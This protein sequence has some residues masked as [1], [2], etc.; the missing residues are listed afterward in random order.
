MLRT[1]MRVDVRPRL[2][3]RDALHAIQNATE[4]DV[5]LNGAPTV[6]RCKL[7]STERRAKPEHRAHV[8]VNHD[9]EPISIEA[10]RA[11][12]ALAQQSLN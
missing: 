7:C 8:D 6:L 12:T 1:L 9:H 4:V 5:A 10:A 11:R 2:E 3:T